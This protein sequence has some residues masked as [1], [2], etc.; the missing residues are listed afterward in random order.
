MDAAGAANDIPEAGN[1]KRVRMI[2][3]A[4]EEFGSIVNKKS[5]G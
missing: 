4:V 1:K 2:F 3:A 5:G